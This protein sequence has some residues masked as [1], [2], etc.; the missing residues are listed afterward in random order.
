MKLLIDLDQDLLDK[1]QEIADEQKRP[2]KQ[3]IQILLDEKINA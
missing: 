3:M 2:R 1:I